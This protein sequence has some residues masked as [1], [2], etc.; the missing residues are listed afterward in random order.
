[1][2][3]A[4][5]RKLLSSLEPGLV[6]MASPGF[7]YPEAILLNEAVKR[8]HKT[9]VV[10]QSWD[11]FSAK[12]F[13]APKP[14]LMVCWGERMREEAITLQDFVAD[15]TIV[16]GAPHFDLYHDL[17]R[18]GSRRLVLER[19]GLDPSRRL[20]VYGTSP[21]VHAQDELDIV[22]RLAEWV[23][24]S[25]THGPF[26]CPLQ[27]LVRLHP[28]QVIGAYSEDLASYRSLIGPHVQL[29]IPRMIQSKADWQM[30][31]SEF[32][33]LPLILSH[34]DVVVNCFSTFGIDGVAAGKPVIC[35][36]FD[37][38]QV[39][40]ERSSARRYLGYTHLKGMTST[41]GVR[42]VFDYD[43]LQQELNAYLADPGRD[44][45]G[46]EALIR[47]QI[48]RIDG[49]SAERTA[50]ALADLAGCPAV[51]HEEAE[52]DLVCGVAA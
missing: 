45:A 27:L 40:D 3:S 39:R 9:A 36:V 32:E 28:Q 14:D 5:A 24:R 11:N 23:Q 8:G 20:I 38:D 22:K 2:R 31:E 1:M 47:T 41:G 35:A 25:P 7:Q 15:K 37:G 26:R 48:Y 49:R 17:S 52:S 42:V 16:C 21:R 50:T 13:V 29:D 46:R 6:V 33:R 34:A 30:D 44:A 12:G 51:E 43:G 19:L 4:A 18:F 10:G